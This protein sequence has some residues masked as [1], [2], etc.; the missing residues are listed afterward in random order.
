VV[1]DEVFGGRGVGFDCGFLIELGARGG[2]VGGEEAGALGGGNLVE[3]LEGD[4]GGGVG[5]SCEEH[6]AGGAGWEFGEF[7]EAVVLLEAGGEIGRILTRF[8]TP[9][10]DEAAVFTVGA[11]EGSD[12]G[13]EAEVSAA[14]E[15]DGLAGGNGAEGD[16]AAV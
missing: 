16:E 12:A 2:L 13:E 14:E 1:E 5:I 6:V 10:E 15:G 11:G 8:D 4:E 9:R 3:G 7:F